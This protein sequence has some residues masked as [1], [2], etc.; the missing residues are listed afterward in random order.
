MNTKFGLK[1]VAT[2]LSIMWFLAVVVLAQTNQSLSR[3]R[4]EG[5]PATEAKNHIHEIATVYGK[6]YRVW[7]DTGRYVDD[8]GNATRYVTPILLDVGGRDTNR[9][10]GIVLLDGDN[11]SFLRLKKFEGK[12]ISVSG[13]IGT[14]RTSGLP[15]MNIMSASGILTWRQSN[16]ST[17]SLAR[18]N[19]NL[20]ETT[21]PNEIKATDR[22]FSWADADA[23]NAIVTV[24]GHIYH[25]AKVTLVEPDGLTIKYT[26][27]GGGFGGIKIPFEDLPLKYQQQYGY[28]PQQAAAYGE[29]QEK[30]AIQ[31]QAQK[32]T[33]EEQQKQTELQ[34]E[35]EQAQLIYELAK[36]DYEKA[37]EEFDT[38]IKLKTLE[39]QQQTAYAQTMQAKQAAYQTAIMRR[40]AIIR[41]QQLWEMQNQTYQQQRTA[42]QINDLKWQMIL[43]H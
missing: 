28:D 2:V 20:Q 22:L 3:S 4:H 23:T 10:F 1:R 32:Q 27:D 13:K 36:A 30:A 21:P 17:S 29:A 16:Q 15:G 34:A 38:Q 43:Y 8:R 12:E 25:H 42:D 5:I 31:A 18:S 9:T 26:P 40:D 19:T 7:F 41:E 6:L 35:A 24:L 39:A 33:Q 37:K 14:N 11:A